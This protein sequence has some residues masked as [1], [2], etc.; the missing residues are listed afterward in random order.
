MDAAIAADDCAL[1]LIFHWITHFR[2]PAM[3]TFD[4]GL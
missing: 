3:I 1:A 2:V 4:F